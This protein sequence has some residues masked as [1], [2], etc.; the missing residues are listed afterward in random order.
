MLQRAKVILLNNDPS[1]FIGHAL[2]QIAAASQ[3][4]RVCRQ[5]QNLSPKTFCLYQLQKCTGN[6]YVYAL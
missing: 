3:G 2:G 1:Q 5:R 4:Q 6:V